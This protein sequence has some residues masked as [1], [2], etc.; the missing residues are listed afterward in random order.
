MQIRTFLANRCLLFLVFLSLLLIYLSCTPGETQ[1]KDTRVTSRATAANISFGLNLFSRLNQSKPAENVFFSPASVLWCLSMVLNGAEGK[2]KDELTS[3]LQV[4][5]L[6]IQ[7]LN[8]IYRDWRQSLSAIDPKVEI[9]IANSIW[10]R[11][12]LGIRPEFITL[13][14]TYYGSDVTEL[15]FNNPQSLGTINSWVKNKTRGKIERIVDQISDDSVLFLINAIYFNGKW[16]RE[17]DASQTKQDR[18]TTLSGSQKQ[19]PM[20]KQRGT[21]SYREHPDFQVVSLPYGNERLSMFVFLPSETSNLKTLRESFTA[22]NWQKWMSEFEKAEGEI[23]LPRF[24]VQYEVD[25]NPALKS[26]GIRAAFDPQQADF[27]AMIRGPK[28]YISGVK[29]KA[30]AEITEEGTVAAASTSTEMRVVS[31]QV[32]QRTFQMIVNRPFLFAIR[33]NASGLILFLGSVAD[34]S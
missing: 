10:S 8:S 21:Y 16:T 34:P 5:G 3:A 17:F 19:I 15:D 6:N 24:S 13:N 32:P 11:Q 20:M 33:D 30:M 18:F 29:H 26:L 31:M 22:Q 12:G 4:T 1:M 28:A 23:A 7:D 9:E 2:T 27:G 25:L 14:R